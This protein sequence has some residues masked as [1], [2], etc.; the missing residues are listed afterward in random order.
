MIK[1]ASALLITLLVLFTG[2][3]Q[4]SFLKQRYTHYG[5][6]KAGGAGLTATK[7]AGETG[8]PGES[9]GEAHLVADAGLV[10]PQP[11]TADFPSALPP[12]LP[13]RHHP[14]GGSVSVQAPP[15]K[16]VETS[17][18]EVTKTRT[19]PVRA[20]KAVGENSTRIPIISPLLRLVF[21]ILLVALVI[22]VVIILI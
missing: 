17:A 1:R 11:G 15:V 7:P 21:L 10:S 14:F 20:R 19:A 3:K 4:A 12:A 2:C 9:K 6:S 16:N 5:H 22:L 13:V 8:K 18:G